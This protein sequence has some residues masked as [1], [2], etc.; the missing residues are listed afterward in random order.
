LLAHP[1]G[2]YPYTLAYH[3][4]YLNSFI[5]RQTNYN[6]SITKIHFSQLLPQL[7][8][9]TMGNSSSAAPEEHT[10]E[11]TGGTGPDVY[12]NIYTPTENSRPGVYHTGIQIGSIEW[13]YGGGSVSSSGIYKQTPKEDPPGGQWVFSKSLHLGKSKI[14]TIE[15]SI[16]TL[17]DK[18]MANEYN[19][20]RKN[21]NHFTEAASKL[22]GVYKNYPDWVNR[23]AR[24]GTSFGM[25]E[26]EAVD[27]EEAK[28]VFESTQGKSLGGNDGK[29]D[30]I[31]LD[32]NGRRNPWVNKGKSHNSGAT[33]GSS[34]TDIAQIQT[35]AQAT[36]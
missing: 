28:T 20:V 15:S 21:C 30:D 26:G 9:I 8:K 31:P 6:L 27:V 17:N 35:T 22:L 33:G 10:T 1:L 5:C 23:L 14:S 11:P 19:V 3:I 29:K 12:L 34:S 13:A 7:L 36:T 18:F 16:N 2:L 25:G 24:M 32:K 4:F